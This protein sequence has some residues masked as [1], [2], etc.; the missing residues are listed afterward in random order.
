M[1]DERQEARELARGSARRTDEVGDTQTAS[2][3]A[4]QRRVASQVVLRGSTQE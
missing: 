3:A 1:R 2:S 4:E